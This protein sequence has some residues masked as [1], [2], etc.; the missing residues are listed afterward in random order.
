MDAFFLQLSTEGTKENLNLYFK[1]TLKVD[2]HYREKVNQ[3]PPA[4]GKFH[5]FWQKRSPS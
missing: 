3:T 2:L 5:N 1:L 4:G